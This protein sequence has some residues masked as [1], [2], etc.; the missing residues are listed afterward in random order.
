M[1]TSTLER[2][3][4]NLLD[5]LIAVK[6]ELILKKLR[7]GRRIRKSPIGWE[8]LGKAA[9]SAWDEVP[10]VDEIRAQREKG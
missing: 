4:D 3:I 1:P 8:K 10:A 7:S 2:R 5:E 6:R 9:S